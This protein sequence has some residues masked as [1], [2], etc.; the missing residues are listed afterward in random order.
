M[1]ILVL[2]VVTKTEAML[3]AKVMNMTNFKRVKE[4]SNKDIW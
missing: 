2:N 3:N 4:T 1:R